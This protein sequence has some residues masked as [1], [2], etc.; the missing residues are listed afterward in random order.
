L[1]SL[2][3]SS[4]SPCSSL[5]A[6]AAVSHPPL[7]RPNSLDLTAVSKTNKRKAAVIA[8]STT[9]EMSRLT[10]A[11]SEGKNNSRRKKKNNAMR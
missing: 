10:R 4:S 9:G 7:C 5:L 6:A 11:M 2:T 8:E 3:S 1:I